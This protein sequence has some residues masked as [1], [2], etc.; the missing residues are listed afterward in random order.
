VTW[1]SASKD[2]GIP[3]ADQDRKRLTLI[4]SD[5]GH[6]LRD[7]ELDAF[8][9]MLDGMKGPLTSRQREWLAKVEERLGADGEVAD[10]DEYLNLISTGQ[11][12]RGREVTINA[13]PKVLR[14]PGRR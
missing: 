8:Q 14:P 3:L 11:A 9:D 4:T 1:A 5:Y 6:R 2:A 10:A 12:P 13:G 7:G